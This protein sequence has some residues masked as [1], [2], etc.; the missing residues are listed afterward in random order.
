MPMDQKRLEAL[1]N[2]ITPIDEIE[3]Y[4][5]GL[6]YGEAGVGKTV[7]ACMYGDDIL[8]VDSA[9]GWVS[10]MNHPEIM[11]KR[12]QRMEY[13]GLSQLD[14]VVEAVMDGRLPFQPKTVI[15]DEGSSMAVKDLD[16]VLR[17]RAAKDSDKDP[18]VPTR[19]DFFANTE[20][21]RRT[22]SKV[23]ALPCNVL[24]LAHVREDKDES[25]GRM[26]TRPAFSPK[27]RQTIVQECHLV[28]Y[29]TA[30]EIKSDGEEVRYLRRLQVH[31]SARI[32]AK[33]RI[34]GF[35][36]VI[37]SPDLNVMLE[38]WTKRVSDIEPEIPK[39]PDG[40]VSE[41]S[42]NEDENIS[43]EGDE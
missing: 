3:P 41:S 34:D 42:V 43:M 25:T 12:I 37:D 9:T 35:P 10:C 11:Q 40:P 16:V 18:D 17:A 1:L 20:R 27:T 6:I 39:E 26:Y 28:G 36:T 32:T 4:F 13:K 38:G 2:T 5:K 23:L 30:N 22:L 14:A 21:V 31:P 29:L 19:P 24:I 33:T 15:L 7:L 8:Y